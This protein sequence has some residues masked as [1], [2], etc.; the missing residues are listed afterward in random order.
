MGYM[1]VPEA[2]AAGG[3]VLARILDGDDALIDRD[4]AGRH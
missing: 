4:D 1:A 2:A 3:S